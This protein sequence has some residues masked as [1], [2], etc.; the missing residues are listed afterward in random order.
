MPKF[1]KRSR[2]RL[3]E[4]DERLQRLFNEVIKSYDCTILCGHRSKEEQEKM[5]EQGRSKLRWPASKH[6]KRP[7]MAVDVAPWPI[8]WTDM[9]SFY[10]FVGYVKRVAE[11]MNIPLRCG[12]DWDMDGYTK[13]QMFN[14][15]VHFE[16]KE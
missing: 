11:E 1:S 8:D 5:Y 14:D 3:E 13:D 9:G 7:S 15:L 6:N 16:L 12:A 10:M 2:K 4:C